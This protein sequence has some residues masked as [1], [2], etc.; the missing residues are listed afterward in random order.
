[1]TALVQLVTRDQIVGES[2]SWVGTR[3]RHQGQRKGVSTDCKGM[4]VGVGLALGLPEARSI[5]AQCRNYQKGFAGRALLDGL[6]RSLIRV[7]AP[8]PGDVLA[9]LMGRDPHPRHLA[10][11]TKPGW[12]VH[13]YFAAEFVA[14]V[15]LSHWRVHSYWT[16]PSLGGADG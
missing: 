7:E 12:I 15:P 16:W 5:D 11:L 1:M 13:A 9:I 10:I 2:L 8:L 14:E 6:G 4:V 3:T